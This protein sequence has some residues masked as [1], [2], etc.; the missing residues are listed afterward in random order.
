MPPPPS[1]T[2]QLTRAIG[3][4]QAAAI[5]IGTIIGTSIFVQPS[6]ITR[7]VPTITGKVFATVPPGTNTGKT[8]RLKGRGIKRKNGKLGDELVKL[9]VVMPDRIDEDLKAF[10]EEW[11]G[12]HR[13]DPRRK[14]REQA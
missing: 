7:E 11:R 5:V 14:H 8:L 10:A 9:T 3:L 12:K 4:P 13:Y 2:P 1:G 6:E